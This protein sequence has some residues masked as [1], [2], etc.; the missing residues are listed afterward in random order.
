MA[1][2]RAQ[3]DG[4]KFT[5]GVL[6]HGND[7]RDSEAYQAC[8]NAWRPCM[9]LVGSYVVGMSCSLTQRSAD[10]SR[11]LA[12]FYQTAMSRPD[13]CSK[14]SSVIAPVESRSAR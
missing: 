10:R 5:L 12:G 1:K 4:K 11:F 9:R 2:K 7:L 14:R 8:V 3:L 13:A 6:K